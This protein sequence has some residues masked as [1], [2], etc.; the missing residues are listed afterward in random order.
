ME[1]SLITKYI[2]LSSERMHVN[3]K[4]KSTFNHPDREKS[5]DVN[6]RLSQTV[7]KISEDGK[8]VVQAI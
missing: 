5:E 4:V 6:R 2:Q 8:G 7:G 1:K 3:N